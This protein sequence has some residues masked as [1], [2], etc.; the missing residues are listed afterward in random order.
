M[1]KASLSM[2]L[3][4][5]GILWAK[6]VVNC[7][8]NL[9]SASRC[10]CPEEVLLRFLK[11]HA[12]FMPLTATF[13][14]Q[15]RGDQADRRESTKKKAHGS[16]GLQTNASFHLHNRKIVADL[17]GTSMMGLYDRGVRSPSHC[18]HC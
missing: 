14:G 12:E 15:A 11:C 2:S 18:S 7:G 17:A 5:N 4:V 1:V 10:A 3:P 13:S 6:R 9:S 16:T 8:G